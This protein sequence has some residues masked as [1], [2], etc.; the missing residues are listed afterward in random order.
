[1]GAIK[2]IQS[3][4][5]AGLKNYASTI[6]DRLRGH[7]YKLSL[8]DLALT[9]ALEKD[10]IFCKFNLVSP[11]DINSVSRLAD[12][13]WRKFTKQ[14]KNNDPKLM[15]YLKEVYAHDLGKI[16]KVLA[17]LKA[18]LKTREA[19][20]PVYHKVTDIYPLTELQMT[21]AMLAGEK[22]NWFVLR[23]YRLLSVW[24]WFRDY[25]KSRR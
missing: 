18:G 11:S 3:L 13:L 6:I 21:E 19:L 5:E 22:P 2:V 8:D 9:R 1:M 20:L 16:P 10:S 14:A 24:Y 12:S 7:D 25:L 4:C 15:K 23:M 17:D